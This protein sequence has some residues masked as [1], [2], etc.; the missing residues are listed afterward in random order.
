MEFEN[1][2]RTRQSV[3]K[4][5]GKEIPRETLQKILELASRAP[6][7][8]NLQAFKVVII[9]DEAMRKKLSKA[10]L[11]Q[12]SVA[13]APVNLVICAVPEE[14][15]AKYGERGR[16]LYAIQDATIFAAYIQ[17]TATNLGLSSVWVGAF[18]EGK[19][20]DILGLEENMIPLAIIP[21]G[22][23]AEKPERKRRK[24][25]EEI[26]HKEI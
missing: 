17:L 6:S 4:F 10:A 1:V 22:F 13:E 21:L 23:S 20:S 16:T 11:D 12:Q 2:L 26:I 5:Q 19:V 18:D 14:S 15:A 25:L 24:G 8:G 7:A 9:K 3:R